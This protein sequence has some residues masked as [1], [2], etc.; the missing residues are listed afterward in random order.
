MPL[1]WPSYWA[2]TRGFDAEKHGAYLMLLG[3]LWMRKGDL[4]ADDPQIPTLAACTE[5]RWAV[6]GPVV[7]SRF[8][9]VDGI[10]VQK[11][12]AEEWNKAQKVSAARKEAGGKGARKRWQLPSVSNPNASQSDT[13]KQLQEQSPHGDSIGAPPAP[14]APPPEPPP[15]PPPAPE[16]EKPPASRGTRLPK[17]WTLPDDWRD[18]GEALRPDLN[19]LLVADSFRDYWVGKSGKDATKLDWLATWRNW[20][21]NQRGAYAAPAARQDRRQATLSGLGTQGAQHADD[22]ASTIDGETRWIDDGP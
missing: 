18:I 15:P 12:L 5:E 21:R 16:P 6:I 22:R 9:I 20:V 2:D 14:P 13:Q 4:R 19:I 10:L 7:L 17:D 3:E 11:R 1:D 8:A